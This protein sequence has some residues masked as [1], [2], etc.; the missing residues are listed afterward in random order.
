MASVALGAPAA[1][2]PGNGTKPH[3]VMFVVDD[4]GWFNVGWHNPDMI[5]P[6]SDRLVKEGIELDRSYVAFYCAPSRSAIMTGR[7]PYHVNQIILPDYVADWDAP[8]EMTAMP[9]KLKQAGYATH[10]VGKWHVGAQDE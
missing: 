9:R 10:M 7:L 2:V 6:H 8:K 3:I 1:G 5:T 4:L